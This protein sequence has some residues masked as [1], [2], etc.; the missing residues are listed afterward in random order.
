MSSAHNGEK[1]LPFSVNMV[2]NG[3]DRGESR[4]NPARVTISCPEKGEV[5]GKLML[6]RGSFQ[7]LLEIGAKKF[8]VSPSK[9]LSKDG[10]EIDD[11]DVIRDGDHLMGTKAGLLLKIL[12][13]FQMS[14][15]QDREPRRLRKQCKD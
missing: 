14:Q 2:R 3:K 6:L 8:G 12:C 9:V 10:A 5:A 1:D 11:I 7:E 15:L 13:K 4:D